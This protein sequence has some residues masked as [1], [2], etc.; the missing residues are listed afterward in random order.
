M[1][2]GSDR[3]GRIQ[4]LTLDCRFQSRK[5]DQTEI[6]IFS[7]PGL[8]YKTTGIFLGLFGLDML[9]LMVCSGAVRRRPVR[10]NTEAI[11]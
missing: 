8:E 3:S 2:T 4:S 6:K 9:K 1:V 10:S 7:L 11:R 5:W